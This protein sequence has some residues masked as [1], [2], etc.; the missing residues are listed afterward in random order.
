M[1]IQQQILHDANETITLHTDKWI[2]NGY[3]KIRNP[4]SETNIFFKYVGKIDNFDFQK[5]LSSPYNNFLEIQEILDKHNIQFTHINVVKWQATI[6]RS[7]CKFIVKTT[8]PN[9]LWYK[10]ES[11]AIGSGNNFIYYKAKKIKTTDFV[12]NGDVYFL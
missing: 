12:K 1:D 3:L 5:I 4:L 9:L 8:N 7:C 6:N 10:Y 11:K 2:T